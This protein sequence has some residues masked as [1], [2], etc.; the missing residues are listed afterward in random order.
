[1]EEEELR[2]LVR[3]GE[4]AHKALAKAAEVVHGG[5][6]LVEL[7]D[8][9]E[10]YIRSS[11]GSPAFPVNIS[12]N[13]VAAHYSPGIKD[14]SEIPR[15]ALVKVD[16]GVHVD[17]YIADAALTL[18]LDPVHSELAKASLEALE[19]A[20]A[21]IRAG[22]R[23]GRVGAAIER[24]IRRRGFEPVRNL[25]GHKISRYSL[26]AGKSIPNTSTLG[27]PRLEKWEVYA[28]E[29]FATSGDG[30]VVEDGNGHIYRV[31]STRRTKDEECDRVLKELW[32][33][34]KS[35]P[36]SERWLVHMV[37]EERVLELLN[38]LCSKRV[39]AYYPILV[40]RSRGP[41]S[42]FE[43]TVVVAPEGPIVTTNVVEL[44]REV[45]Y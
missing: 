43:D 1:M 13:E 22:I 39:V 28:V 2:K 45:L 44:G 27:G 12:I 41:V 32:S 10:S 20:E 7:A 3:A 24:A 25:T 33:R 21:E 9:L 5:M 18:P 36:F 40:E 16:L 37:P 23:A 14:P 26:H 15:G 31:V 19:A 38:V 17:G 42:Q 29:P 4:I 35:L 30:M 11:G 34:F 8:L 6:P